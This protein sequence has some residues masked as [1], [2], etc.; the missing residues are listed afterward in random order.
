MGTDGVFLDGGDQRPLP[1]DCAVR[2]PQWRLLPRH[3]LGGAHVP[4]DD[5]RRSMLGSPPVVPGTIRV[6][7]H[8]TQTKQIIVPCTTGQISVGQR[9]HFCT[10]AS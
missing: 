6:G 4:A 10:V 8:N 1:R 7:T 9:K 2:R 5:R 3:S